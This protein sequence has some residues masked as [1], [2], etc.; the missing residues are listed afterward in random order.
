[1]IRQNSYLILKRVRQYLTLFNFMFK[2]G[3][4]IDRK[5]EQIAKKLSENSKVLDLGCGN[6]AIGIF[7]STR[8]FAVTCVDQDMEA[9]KG[10]KENHPDINVVSKNILDFS[11]PQEEYN[12]VLILN[13]LHFLKFKEAV[14]VIKKSMESLKHGGFLYLKVFSTRDPSYH[15]FATFHSKTEEKNTFYSNKLKKFMHFFTED[16]LYEIL[17]KHKILKMTD[18]LVWDNHPPYGAHK[19]GILTVLVEK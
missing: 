13:V 15:K 19:H 7:L 3:R 12:L 1:L 6:G 11:F 18:E 10:I 2:F 17:K 14:K 4:K 16:E 5:I 9:L 8:E